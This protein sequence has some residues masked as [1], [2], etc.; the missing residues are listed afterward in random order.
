MEK[1]KDE[2]QYT[3]VNKLFLV[4]GKILFEN[5]HYDHAPYG[6]TLH[7]GR[8]F[9]SFFYEIYLRTYLVPRCLRL[10]RK[11]KLAPEVLD[12]ENHYILR[13]KSYL[14]HLLNEQ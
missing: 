11:F 5:K 2:V 9:K 14:E 10:W 13:A 6:I 7:S 3:Q 12:L 1:K 8:L 4:L